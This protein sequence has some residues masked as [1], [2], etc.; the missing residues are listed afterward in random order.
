MCGKAL[1]LH[2]LTINSFRDLYLVGACGEME[3]ASSSGVTPGE[4]AGNL[5]TNRRDADLIGV[6]NAE[7]YRPG[8]YH[9]VAVG[10]I[11]AGR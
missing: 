9:P 10:D 4:A 7:E 8:G 2:S 6:E 5:A 1:V 11:L 3:G